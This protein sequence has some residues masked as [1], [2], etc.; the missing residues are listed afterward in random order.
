MMKL[1]QLWLTK[2]AM[3]RLTRSRQL[4]LSLLK[5]NKN[6]QAPKATCFDYGK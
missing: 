5:P 1:K 3:K 6:S 4:T 2:K